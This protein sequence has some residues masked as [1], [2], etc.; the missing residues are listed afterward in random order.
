MKTDAEYNNKSSCSTP[1]KVFP[2]Q[3]ESFENLGILGEEWWCCL[4]PVLTNRYFS[5]MTKSR[6]FKSLNLRRKADRSL[7]HNLLEKHFRHLKLYSNP[8]ADWPKVLVIWV[9]FERQK[10]DEVYIFERASLSGFA[11]WKFTMKEKQVFLLKTLACP[12]TKNLVYFLREN[13]YIRKLRS[14]KAKGFLFKN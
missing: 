4:N 9:L 3:T 13:V 11:S 6:I 14:V 8:Q 2:I 7:C 10:V 12:E 1:R 5:H